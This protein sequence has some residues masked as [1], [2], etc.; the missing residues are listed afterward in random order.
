MAMLK[1]R[2]IARVSLSTGGN[3]TTHQRLGFSTLRERQLV[4]S[5]HK[6]EP[7]HVG[8]F[9]GFGCPPELVLSGTWDINW[10]RKFRKRQWGLEKDLAV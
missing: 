6:K 2:N 3:R 9:S 10:G 1:T 8:W 5:R 4:K 7:W